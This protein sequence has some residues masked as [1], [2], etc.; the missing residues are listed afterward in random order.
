MRLPFWI[1]YFD[2]AFNFFTSFGYFKTQREH[3]NA[4]RTIAQALKP[5]GCFVMD[6]LNV[7]FSEKRGTEEHVKT[8]DTT[9]Y[10]ITKW[11]DETHF[12]KKIGVEDNALSLPLLYTEK[13]SKFTL[14]DFQKMFEKQG[15]KINEVYGDYHF[16]DHDESNS[17]RL[18]M[19]AVKA[20]S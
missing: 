18:I 13:V 16:N 3:D 4:I 7:K 9:T 15:L 14:E 17:P 2:H 10:H 5:G 11:T 6:F 8:I 20:Y 12:Y 1:N 19:I